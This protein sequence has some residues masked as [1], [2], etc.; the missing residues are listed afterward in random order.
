LGPAAAVPIGL[1]F[2]SSSQSLSA[3]TNLDCSFTTSSKQLIRS[4]SSAKYSII[5]YS[6]AIYF[7]DTPE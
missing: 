4:K 1:N 7:P 5:K 6:T 2:L 3:R